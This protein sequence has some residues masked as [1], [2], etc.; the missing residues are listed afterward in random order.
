MEFL[1]G[2]QYPDQFKFPSDLLDVRTERSSEAKPAERFAGL[3]P[4]HPGAKV[5]PA[6]FFPATNAQYERSVSHALA[7]QV[8]ALTTAVLQFGIS[9]QLNPALDA[10]GY[11][12]FMRKPEIL[13]DDFATPDYPVLGRNN[14]GLVFNGYIGGKL[15]RQTM[16]DMS[17]ISLLNGNQIAPALDC[18][19]YYG[20]EG[21]TELRSGMAFFQVIYFPGKDRT[22]PGMID[23]REHL[24]ALIWTNNL[25]TNEQI[26]K[27][28]QTGTMCYDHKHFNTLMSSDPLLTSTFTYEDTQTPLASSPTRKIDFRNPIDWKAGGVEL[29]V[30]NGKTEAEA[31]LLQ[32]S[33]TRITLQQFRGETAGI[34]LSVQQICDSV[35]TSKQ[36]KAVTVMTL[37]GNAIESQTYSEPNRPDLLVMRNNGQQGWDIVYKGKP[38]PVYLIAA[39]EY[40]IRFRQH[41]GAVAMKIEFDTAIGMIRNVTADLPT[42]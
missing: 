13:G 23:E 38:V 8:A 24:P 25:V 22:M 28:R 18:D 29:A 10:F 30:R 42:N 33:P 6:E 12:D 2:Y 17:D 26:V 21:V 19:F 37:D 27:V 16:L 31:E 39:D 14:S 3:K 41:P 34:N 32:S 40:G 36:L 4:A 9:D 20:G 1:P 5:I 7:F 35:F 15:Y 11:T